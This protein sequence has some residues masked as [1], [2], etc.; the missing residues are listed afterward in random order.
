MGLLGEGEGVESIRLLF[1]LK[2]N[3]RLTY[4]YVGIKSIDS[5]YIFT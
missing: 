3:D 2:G 1:A 5:I 4:S